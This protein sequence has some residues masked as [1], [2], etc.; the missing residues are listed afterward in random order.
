MEWH[1][2]SKRA[3]KSIGA[4]ATVGGAQGAERP[5]TGRGPGID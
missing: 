2:R 4:F 1:F 3:S 5:S